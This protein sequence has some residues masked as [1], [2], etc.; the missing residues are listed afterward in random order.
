MAHFRWKGNKFQSQ[1]SMYEMWTMPI[2]R[3]IK[4]QPLSFTWLAAY[5]YQEKFFHLKKKK[6][7]FPTYR[8]KWFPEVIRRAISFREILEYCVL[9]KSHTLEW[10]EHDMR[11]IVSWMISQQLDSHYTIMHF[12]TATD[13]ATIWIFKSTE[14]S[15]NSKCS[16]LFRQMPIRAIHVAQSWGCSQ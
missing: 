15:S 2:F 13:P 16:F 9:L 11:S 1:F 14:A 3:N 5:N 4:P 12:K 6:K 8:P 10:N 7:K